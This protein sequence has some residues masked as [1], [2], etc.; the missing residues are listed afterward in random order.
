MTVRSPSDLTNLFIHNNKESI[1]T[2]PIDNYLE[3]SE[4]SNSKN[5]DTSSSSNCDCS[6][7]IDE[8]SIIKNVE[9]N[10]GVVSNKNSV[11]IAIND[12]IVYNGD[13][14]EDNDEDEG[15][16]DSILH[17]H[18]TV[19][20]R[21][22]YYDNVPA[23]EMTM[24]SKSTPNDVK[25]DIPHNYFVSDLTLK[26]VEE[27]LQ[28]HRQSFDDDDDDISILSHDEEDDEEE[29]EAYED[30]H[31]LHLPSLMGHSLKASC[32][33]SVDSGVPSSPIMRSPR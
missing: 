5:T 24:L 16:Q 11:R 32:M 2:F 15:D 13:N 29:E 22:S 31:H 28:Q 26:E 30:V 21:H 23:E 17:H 7:P 14:E 9:C 12:H 1:G 4:Y 33:G 20:A 10:G 3:N 18:K 6:R 25:F 19:L 27:N 8:N